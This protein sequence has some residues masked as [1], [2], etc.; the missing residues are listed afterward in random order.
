MAVV[1][2]GAIP[3]A[4]E[5]EMH[6]S[7]PMTWHAP[8]VCKISLPANNGE[9][10]TASCYR[11]DFSSFGG[12]HNIV[13]HFQSSNV[14]FILPA[15]IKSDRMPVQSIVFP[16]SSPVSIVGAGCRYR[17]LNKPNAISVLQCSAP[18]G[19]GG[20]LVFTAASPNW[21]SEATRIFQ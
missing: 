8:P 3:A 18:D 12:T 13:W 11:V 20:R 21:P 1:V 7:I 4:A 2:T 15:D 17:R 5:Y 14:R 10:N 16:G 19:V 6:R 9:R